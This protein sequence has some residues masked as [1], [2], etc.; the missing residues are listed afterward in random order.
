M[1]EAAKLQY[2]EAKDALKQ[3][4]DVIAMLGSRQLRLEREIDKQT[5]EHE[6]RMNRFADSVAEFVQTQIV[7]ERERSKKRGA[8]IDGDNSAPGSPSCTEA[9]TM[10]DTMS[11]TQS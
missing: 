9:Q 11:E 6:S 2:Q 8:G 3:K 5:R 4:A 1:A 10:A 7:A